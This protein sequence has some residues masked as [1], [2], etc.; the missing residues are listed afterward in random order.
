M[1]RNPLPRDA[2]TQLPQCKFR[3]VEGCDPANTETYWRERYPDTNWV[4]TSVS[5]R[6]LGVSYHTLQDVMTAHPQFFHCHQ[7][8]LLNENGK[9]IGRVIVS[10]CAS[11]VAGLEAYKFVVLEQRIARAKATLRLWIWY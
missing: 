4:C 2:C 7:H 3:H 5:A 10:H 11:V 8:A 6:A 9:C 1:P